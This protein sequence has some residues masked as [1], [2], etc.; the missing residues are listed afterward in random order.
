MLVIIYLLLAIMRGLNGM[1]KYPIVR[2]YFA[3]RFLNEQSQSFDP[4]DWP[5]KPEQRVTDKEEIDK[6]LI[7][8]R[9][10]I[11]A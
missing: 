8:N 10:L 9:H 3:K 4:I 6:Y 1:Q 5:S 2:F 7:T 11:R